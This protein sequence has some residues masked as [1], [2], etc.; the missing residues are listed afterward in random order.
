MDWR[1]AMVVGGFIGR[2]KGFDFHEI[3]VLDNKWRRYN[4]IH[5]EHKDSLFF[6]EKY[7]VLREYKIITLEFETLR[8]MDEHFEVAICPVCKVLYIQIFE[9]IQS[10]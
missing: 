7:P 1:T 6:K 3:K 5:C 8:Y 9:R 2:T 4:H 10:I